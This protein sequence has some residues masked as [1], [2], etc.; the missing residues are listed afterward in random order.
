MKRL[1]KQSL[2]LICIT[3][4]LV[5]SCVSNKQKERTISLSGAFALYPL[6]VKWSE[7]YKKENPEIRFNISCGGAG[8]GMADAISGATDLG[9]FSREITQEEKDK[10]VWWVGLSIDAVLPTINAQNPYLDVLKNTGWPLKVAAKVDE[11]PAPTAAEL[12][13]LAQFDPQGFWTGD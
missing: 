11:T 13:M 10:G 8:K 7:E 12:E 6:V 9:M 4:I 3:S 1:V 2:I 5:Y